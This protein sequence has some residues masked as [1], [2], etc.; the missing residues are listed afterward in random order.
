MV[1]P[2]FEEQVL[3]A[4]RV[5]AHIEQG[6]LH[7]CR[8]YLGPDRFEAAKSKKKDGGK[9][10]TQLKSRLCQTPIWL[11]T[12]IEKKRRDKDTNDKIKTMFWPSER[13]CC[14]KSEEKAKTLHR[15]RT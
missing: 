8:P 6:A 7:A 11:G 2:H 13:E 3:Q 10:T 1:C 15:L 9:F 5:G 14:S 12:G 4:R